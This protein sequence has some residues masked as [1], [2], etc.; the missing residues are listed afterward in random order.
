[1]I[2]ASFGLS[3]E[4]FHR[5][6][7]TLL[8][9]QQTIADILHIQAQHGGFAVVIGA[10]GLGKTTLREHLE[11]SAHSGTDRGQTIVASFSRTLHTY[12]QLLAQLAAALKLD[13]PTSKLETEL[14]KTAFDI[15]RSGKSLYLIIDEAHLIDTTHL[16]KLRLLFERFPK[17]HLLVLLGHPE[18]LLNLSL[19]PNSDIKQRITYS[20][21]LLPLSDDHLAHFIQSELSAAGLGA[22]TFNDGALQLILRNAAGNLRLARNLCH[23]SLVQACLEQTRHVLTSHVN[24]VL[25]QPHWRSHDQLFKGHIK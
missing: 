19:L 13:C 9:Q 16:R 1:M 10:P 24:N 4:P 2:K 20:A 25:I 8:Q 3:H 18:L 15:H 21:T 23:S 5:D 17:R 7:I 14:I 11:T 6:A 22:N 12:T